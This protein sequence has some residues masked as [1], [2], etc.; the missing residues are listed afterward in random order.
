[1]TRPE[2]VS[3]KEYI[4]LLEAE[5]LRYEESPHV[6][7]YLTIYNQI[8]DWNDQLE[9]REDERNEDGAAKGRIDLF[10]DAEGK[11]FDRAFKYIDKC[12]EFSAKLDNLRKMMNP[13]QEKRLAKEMETSKLGI[14]ERMALKSIK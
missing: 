13:E 1:M 4:K 14:A 3:D 2:K 12:D 11:S 9:I 7:T 8:S 10:S 5:L 6:N